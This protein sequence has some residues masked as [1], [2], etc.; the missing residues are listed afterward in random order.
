MKN[1]RGF[2]LAIASQPFMEWYGLGRSCFFTAQAVL[3]MP[4]FRF[5]QSRAPIPED[6]QEL[7]HKDPG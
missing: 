2:S 4:D 5:V 1:K 7:G 6:N 3:G